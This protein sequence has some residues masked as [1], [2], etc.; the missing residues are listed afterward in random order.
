MRKLSTF[1]MYLFL[2]IVSFISI[3]PFIWVGIS[4]TNSSVDV[5]KGKL[6]PGSE[7]FNN[8]NNLLDTTDIL[9][10]FKNSAIVS[11]VTIALALIVSSMAGYAFVIYESKVKE[12]IFSI[13][14]L[15]MMIPFAAILIPLYKL[16]GQLGLLN[17]VMGVV[18]PSVA[19]AFLIFFF[20]QNTKA[21]PKELLEAGRIDGVS[22]YGLFFK[23]F[24]PTMGSTYAAAAIITFMTAWNNYLWP[25]VALQS[26]DKKTLPLVLS[27]LNASYVPDYGM[28]MVGVL[29]STIPTLI[30]FFTMQKRF[31]EG[32]IGSVK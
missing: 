20:R 18:L 17:S 4:A 5:S 21:F 25:L 12:I 23:L 22:E 14:L 1:G 15:S 6:T 10:G 13:L 7:F 30:V 9:I 8:L 3:F 29:I 2:I 11:I 27:T 19:T 16:F 26:A 28:I 32:M 24:I 31:V